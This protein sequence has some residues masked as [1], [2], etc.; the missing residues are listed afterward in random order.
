VIEWRRCVVIKLVLLALL[1][2]G[3]TTVCAFNRLEA[4]V[5]PAEFRASPDDP[6]FKTC[7]RVWIGEGLQPGDT[8]LTPIY[9]APVRPY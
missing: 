8:P 5:H 1:L 4:T 6:R 9:V 2:S 3:C 7:Y